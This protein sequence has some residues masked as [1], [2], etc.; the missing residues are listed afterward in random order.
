MKILKKMTTLLLF[1]VL[2]VSL[3]ACGNKGKEK[4]NESIENKKTV[5]LT[6]WE[7]SRSKDDFDEQQEAQFLKEHPWIKLKKVVKEGDPGNEFYQS[8]AAGTAPDFVEASFTVTNQLAKN[9]VIAPINKYLEKWDEG[10][11]FDKK[12][13]DILSTNGNTYGLPR[14][15]NPMLFAYNKSI[16]KENN[17]SEAPKNWDEALITGKKVNNPDKKITGYAT[18]TSEWTEWFFQYYVWQAGG[19]LTQKNEDGTIKLTFTDPAVIKA[20]KYYQTL[21]KNNLLPSDRTLKFDDLITQFSQGNIAMM[22][23][24]TDWVMDVINRGM[25]I[26]DLGLTVAPAGPSGKS[27]T[28]ING[29]CFVINAKSS[30]EKQDAAWEYIS[31]Y[32]SKA[33]REA[34]YKNQDSKGSLAPI[35]LP[36]NDI[37][38]TDF[39]NLPTEYQEVLNTAE[40]EARLEFYGKAEFGTFVDRAVQ[41]I[42]SN[43]VVEPKVEFEKAQKTAEDEALSAFN[44][45]AKDK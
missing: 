44:D 15:V 8:V 14:E 36:R 13:L 43:P 35:I 33:Q 31:F 41:N 25:D 5:E 3:T 42:L 4:Q 28:A 21:A 22:P 29:S 18:L 12:Y 27:P 40:K 23:F 30:K 39:G 1:S 24:A 6:V 20:A 7:N 26:D 38:I 19:D 32:M 17:I 10:K 9:G 11:E 34:Y 45:T 37:K 2:L 16:F